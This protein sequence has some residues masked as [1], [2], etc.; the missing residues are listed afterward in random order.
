M[1]RGLKFLAGA[2][3]VLAF[4]GSCTSP[5]VR[6]QQAQANPAV[7]AERP[8]GWANDRSDLPKDPDFTIGVLPNGM[9]YMILP[10]KTPP[11]QV[12]MRLVISAGS[13]HE[14]KGEEGIAHFL[15]H[16]AFRGTKVFPDGELQRR[17]EGLGLQMGADANASTAPTQT[18]FKFNLAR[19]DVESIDTGLLVLR[20]I[21]S[22][23]TIQ[24]EM[25]DAE[26]GV[27]L[28]EERTRAGPG[29]EAQKQF[30]KLQVG[31]HPY[32]RSPIGLRDVV[33]TV[34]PAQIR[35]FY[36]AYYRPER[37]TLIVIGDTKP[38]NLLPAI[39]ARFGD[40]KG[41]GPAGGDP[42]P[43]TVKPPAPEIAVDVTPGLGDTSVLLRWFEP[44]RERPPTKAERRKQLVETLG[45]AAVAERMQDLSDAAGRPAA[46]I[47]SASPYRVPTVWT[48]QMAQ[49][50]GITDLTKAIDV[51]V[52]SQRQAVQ[53]GV[54]Q[55]ELDHAITV[56]REM[57]KQMAATGRTGGSAGMA[58]A[59][60]ANLDSDPLF[61][62]PKD[63]LALFEEQVKT[64]K[65]AEVNTA[66]RARFTDTPTLIYRGSEQPKGGEAALKAAYAS[67]KAKPVTAYAMAAVKPWPYTN[68]GTPGKVAERK[69]VA[70]LGITF[71]RFEN[72]VRLT[73]KPTTY[74]KDDVLVR[75]R[76]GLGRIGMPRDRI[77]ASD[78]GYAIWTT[79]GLG[80]L[81]RV[82]QDR[83]LAGRRVYA[84]VESD[85]DAYELS[86]G[87]GGYTL[88]SDFRLQM[89]LMAAMV[90]D[91]RLDTGDWAAMITASDQSEASAP[92]TPDGVVGFNLVRLLH[93]GD[94]RWTYNTA[95]M[96]KTWKP[97]EAVSY[98][99]PIIANSPMEVIV[100]GDIPVNKAIE[101]VAR[102]FGALPKRKEVKEPAGLRDVKF[103]KGGA[104]VVLTHKGRADQAAI[105]VAWPTQGMMGNVREY[106]AGWVLAQMLRDEATR[107]FRSD[108]SAT[109]SP[110]TMVDFSRVLPDYGYVGVSMEIEPSRAD[111]AIAAIESIARTL[112][113][114][115]IPAGE[116]TRIT[117]PRAAA[118]R[119]EMAN[120]GYWMTNL[121]NAQT[122]PRQLDA[123]RTIVSDY[124]AITPEE[125]QAVAKKW[126]QP[127]RAWKLKVVP[128]N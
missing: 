36:D 44:Y 105:A 42:S 54:T 19:N 76:M 73:V 90:T 47:I 116:V 110:S 108:D 62:S 91:P 125:V 34:T 63:M 46:A 22:E 72:G 35:K 13:M 83:T 1:T 18:I 26:R 31:E 95:E 60:A 29:E 97:E 118:I 68:F 50:A 94:L 3:A 101:D 45:V 93:S 81:T 59:Y 24:P 122:D 55:A 106:R 37:A 65:L 109:Y 85:D 111:G 104:P 7:V 89:E 70:D 71:V 114:Y 67:A 28:S 117:G 10:N 40:W 120:N 51:L 124:Q 99:K 88:A 49:A 61:M 115:P 12:A 100:V 77:D 17:L 16:L 5:Q 96:R 9:R 82:E 66:L 6:F 33:S 127:D 58:E 98:I 53:Y 92:L 87:D 86:N 64:V 41:R 80:K 57:M 8:K 32:A 38:E 30:I 103:P 128:E 102:T 74:Q 112:I 113:T 27:V 52:T 79:G 84:G 107:K 43:V 126:L 23:L 75:V 39:K 11:N 20:E 123:M 78:M 56:R 25:V 121:P 2:L 14:R 21:V 15:E 69:E 119:R 4:A 48:G